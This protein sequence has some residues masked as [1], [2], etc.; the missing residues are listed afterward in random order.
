MEWEKIRRK[1]DSGNLYI[2]TSRVYVN[3]WKVVEENGYLF[4]YIKCRVIPKCGKTHNVMG[5]GG[6]EGMLRRVTKDK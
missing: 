5:E 1:I 2:D 3:K 6:L 4:C